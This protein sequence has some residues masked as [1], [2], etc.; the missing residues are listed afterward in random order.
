MPNPLCHFELMTNDAAKCKKF[1][2][3]VFD[4]KFDE[5]AMPGYTLIQTGVEPGGGIF[6]KPPE[7]PGACMNVYFHV[8]DVA[9][10]LNKAVSQGAKVLIPPMPIPNVGEIAMFADPEGIVVGLYKPIAA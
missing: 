5:S 6:P 1:Y 2:A 3:A 8:E 9:A 4:W 10:T 7:A